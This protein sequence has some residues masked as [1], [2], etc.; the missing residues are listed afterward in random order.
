MTEPT[1]IF[2]YVA[3]ASAAA[4]YLYTMPT[5]VQR[6]DFI[7]PGKD[8]RVYDPTLVISAYDYR[9]NTHAKDAFWLNQYERKDGR[10]SAP[11]R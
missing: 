7:N 3:A 10:F 5:A 2:F 1:P 6:V 9:T 11:P 4:Y 8:F